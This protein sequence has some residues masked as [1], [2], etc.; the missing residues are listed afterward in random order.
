MEKRGLQFFNSSDLYSWK[1]QLLLIAQG[2]LGHGS[3]DKDT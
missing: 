3:S 1:V 2:L